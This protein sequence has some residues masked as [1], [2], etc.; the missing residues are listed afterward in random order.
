MRKMIRLSLLLNIAVL[1]PVCLGLLLDAAWVVHAY[2]TA[3]AARGILLSVYGAILI[4]STV[5]LLRQE[6]MLVAP[7]LLVQVVYKLTTPLTVGSLQNPVVISNIVIAA[8]HLATLSLI[9]REMRRP[10]PEPAA[11]R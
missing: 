11:A 1:I 6:A 2:G 3:T 7:L 10:V 5:L 8:V 4:V 9:L